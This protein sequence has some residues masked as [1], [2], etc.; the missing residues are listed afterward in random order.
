MANRVVSAVA[1][2]AEMSVLPLPAIAR[3]EVAVVRMLSGSAPLRS[4]LAEL[5]LLPGARVRVLAS[6][7]PCILLVGGETRLCLRGEEAESVLV[8]IA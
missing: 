3:D 7:S 8:Q 1:E 6:G 5:G 2:R 4:R